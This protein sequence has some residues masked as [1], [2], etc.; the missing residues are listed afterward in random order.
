[1]T[2]DICDILQSV[3]LDDYLTDPVLRQEDL[4]TEHLLQV[5][6]LDVECSQLANLLQADVKE[7]TLSE[8]VGPAHTQPYCH[9]DYYDQDFIQAANFKSRYQ[10]NIC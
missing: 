5:R 7:E 3:D 9:M 4:D 6:Y 10:L 2:C 8:T 1:M